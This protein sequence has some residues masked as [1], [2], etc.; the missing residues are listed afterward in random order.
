VTE[1]EARRDVAG[2]VPAMADEEAFP[3]GDAQVLARYI[4]EGGSS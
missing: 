2:V 1:R 4:E 3:I